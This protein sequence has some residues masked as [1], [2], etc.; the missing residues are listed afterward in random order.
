MFISVT[1]IMFQDDSRNTREN[2]FGN[3]LLF[4]LQTK[5][6]PNKYFTSSVIRDFDEH[7][8]INNSFFSL[9][10]DCSFIFLD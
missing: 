3:M 1:A 2:Y 5:C 6:I 9:I 7:S 8:E 10:E 4:E